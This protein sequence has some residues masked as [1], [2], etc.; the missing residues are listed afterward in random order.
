M[1]DTTLAGSH[2]L[3]PPQSGPHGSLLEQPHGFPSS[4]F[5]TSLQGLKIPVSKLY[6]MVYNFEVPNERF[7]ET[8]IRVLRKRAPPLGDQEGFF[9][10]SV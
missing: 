10:V 8:E 5:R 9:F 3:P 6:L 1:C 2:G 7:I 4:R